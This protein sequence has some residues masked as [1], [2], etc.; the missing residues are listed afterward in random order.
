MKMRPQADLGILAPELWGN[1][2]K[3]YIDAKLSKHHISLRGKKDYEYILSMQRKPRWGGYCR[4]PNVKLRM[5]PWLLKEEI[6]QPTAID[7]E[8]YFRYLQ[9]KGASLK[10]INKILYISRNFFKFLDDSDIYKNNISKVEPFK[11]RSDDL[12]VREYITLDLFRA[13]ISVIDQT[14][15]KGLRDVAIISIAFMR[16]AR[17]GSIAALKQRDFIYNRRNNTY[18]LRF[19][20]KKMRDEP[21]LNRIPKAAG[22]AVKKYLVALKREGIE[23]KPNQPLFISVKRITEKKPMQMGSISI[24]VKNYLRKLT[25]DG[26]LD[27]SEL[28][29]L[30]A[31]SLKHG[32]TSI[33]N[34]NFGLIDANVAADHRSVETTKR[35]IHT[36]NKKKLEEKIDD[37]FTSLIKQ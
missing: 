14:K 2:V 26:L 20:V 21:E 17:I 18:S 16:G 12:H 35:Y 34:Q 5:Y 11:I 27:Q 9:E 24:M 29:H 13:L 32:F 37:L 4:D 36:K 15:V 8:R 1:C 7:L 23:L 25:Q 28:A 3:R 10:T 19:A 6:Y 33:I 22:K 31:H 30:C